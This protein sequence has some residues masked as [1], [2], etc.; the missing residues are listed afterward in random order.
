MWETRIQS[1]TQCNGQVNFRPKGK[2]PYDVNA[3]D[4][5]SF[6]TLQADGRRRVHVIATRTQTCDGSVVPNVMDED[7]LKSTMCI[8]AAFGGGMTV[9]DLTTADG[10]RTLA[11]L[12]EAAA[13][14][15]LMEAAAH[16]AWYRSTCAKAKAKDAK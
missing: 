6:A 10:V 16:E 8:A 15:P 11:V 14:V 9:C 3:I 1:K 12:Y 2:V 7:L 5:F 13:A 4:A